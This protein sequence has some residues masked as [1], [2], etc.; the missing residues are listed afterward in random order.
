MNDKLKELIQ[1]YWVEEQQGVYIPLIDKVLLKNNV[2]EMSYYDYMEYAKSNGV[3]IATRDELLQMYLQKDEINK[4]LREHNGDMLDTWFGSS[5]KHGLYSEW[6]VNFGSGYC[7]YTSN[8]YS[9]VSRAV[10]D[11]KLK[12]TN[13]MKQFNLEEYKKNPNRK[14]ITRDGRDVRILC[15]DRQG[16]DHPIIAL[17]T[18]S[19]GIEI[20]FSYLHNGRQY[21]DTDSCNDLFFDTKNMKDGLRDSCGD[22]FVVIG[23]PWESEEVARSV[24]SN[25]PNFI[26]TCKII[27]EE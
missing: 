5:S 18:A 6:L 12:K 7:Y 11:L 16:G 14:V 3:Q 21:A 27:W 19:S 2:P 20:Y 15:T 25:K 13:N 4:I 8:H 9:Y 26:A 23:S 22:A 24:V 17:C 1:P 10:A